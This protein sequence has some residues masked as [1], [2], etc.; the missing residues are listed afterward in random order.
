[1]SWGEAWRLYNV[2]ASDPSTAIAAAQ[3]GWDY[4]VSRDFM[5][6]AD[7]Y[8]LTHQIAAGG[9]TVKPYPRPWRL[10]DKSRFGRT[11]LPQDKVRALL[12]RR[13]PQRETPSTP[14]PPARRRD[15]RGRF[16]PKE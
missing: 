11:S 5:A 4:A 14:T 12:A 10:A 8:D 16:L 1:M 2:L 7:L 6:T 9:K 13:G 3:E 15:A